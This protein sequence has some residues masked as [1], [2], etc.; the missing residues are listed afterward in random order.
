MH[1][2]RASAM[3]SS[4]P[5]WRYTRWAAC[6][7]DAEIMGVTFGTRAE[8]VAYAE[9]VVRYAETPYRWRDGRINNRLRAARKE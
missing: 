6:V 2:P 8:A 3:R 5:C 7:D 9:G 4:R 1:N